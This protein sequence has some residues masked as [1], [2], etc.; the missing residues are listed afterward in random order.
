[1][2]S[3]DPNIRFINA[4]INWLSIFPDSRVQIDADYLN[5]T[6]PSIIIE[7]LK[8]LIGSDF[9]VDSSAEVK[10]EENDGSLVIN[11]DIEVYET[12]FVGLKSY[13]KSKL[14]SRKKLYNYVGMLKYEELKNGDLYAL[15]IL[16]FILLEVGLH[17]FKSSISISII[18]E[19]NE[20]DQK[21][22]KNVM[23]DENDLFGKN[24]MLT[25]RLSALELENLKLKESFKK[26]E[27]EQK[28]AHKHFEI[29]ENEKHGIQLEY[30]KAL[31]DKDLELEKLKYQLSVF[32]N[33]NNDL[34]QDN[35][36][37]KNDLEDI[38]KFKSQLNRKKHNYTTESTITHNSNGEK[39]I[40]SDE[41]KWEYNILSSW[42]NRLYASK[43]AR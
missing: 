40:A 10:D 30:E 12:I 20:D 14:F 42:L 17:S 7:V 37:L 8:T 16:C 18:S 15:N 35:L 6:D 2:A 11:S 31:H 5:L 43:K 9:E 38:G 34:K 25:Q 32:K 33:S 41:L 21:E 22:L 3:Q 36:Q 13:F 28:T 29:N 26:I 27:Q 1:M 39:S 23:Y 19:L 24:L 4:V